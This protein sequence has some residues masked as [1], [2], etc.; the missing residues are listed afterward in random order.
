MISRKKKSGAR[1]NVVT[2]WQRAGGLYKITIQSVHPRPV[3][4]VSR[5]FWDLFSADYLVFYPYFSSFPGIK[6]HPRVRVLSEIQLVNQSVK[7]RNKL[8]L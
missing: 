6:E 5:Y 4:A 2:T 3:G 8:I 7:N 1:R